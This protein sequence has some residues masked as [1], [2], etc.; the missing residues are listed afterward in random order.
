M[1]SRS[2]KK[3]VLPKYIKKKSII[4]INRPEIHLM[5]RGAADAHILSELHLDKK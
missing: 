5:L 4:F 2:Q 3:K 1:I